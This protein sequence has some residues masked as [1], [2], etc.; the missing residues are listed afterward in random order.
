MQKTMGKIPGVF[1][2][3][4]QKHLF[5]ELHQ[6]VKQG[7]TSGILKIKHNRSNDYQEMEGESQSK[8][9]PVGI[10]A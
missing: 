8:H 5:E 1:L 3:N 4:I 6:E 2:N 10:V 7:L 9:E